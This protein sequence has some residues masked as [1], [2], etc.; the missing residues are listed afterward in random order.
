[1]P[2]T[3]WVPNTCTAAVDNATAQKWC[4]AIQRQV[5][6]DVAPIWS[7]SAVIH[8]VGDSQTEKPAAG[9]GVVPIVRASSND[10]TLGSHWLDA[11]NPRGEVGAQTCLDDGVS[12]SS[13][14]S[15]ELL[16][17]IVDEYAT[18]CFQVGK[19]I[20]AGELCDRVEDSDDS[21]MIDGVLVENFSRP[22]AF[23]D[24][25]PGPW[26]FR[27]KC[28]SNIV[29]PGGYQLVYD[30]ST[31]Q[32]SQITGSLARRSKCRAALSSRRASRILRSGHDPRKLALAAA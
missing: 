3:I 21:Y 30:L 22:A 7:K 20:L 27:S 31:G 10:G 28:Q 26:D 17:M 25:A 32:W 8:Y 6:L 12:V 2:S 5:A 14:L 11:Q 15:H 23:L 1:M 4:D 24:G 18:M 19:L 13:C 16:E 9:D 29:L